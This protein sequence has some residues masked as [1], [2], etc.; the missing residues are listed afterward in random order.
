MATNTLTVT[1]QANF[2]PEFWA[3]EALEAVEFAQ[4]IAK[5]VNRHWE[6]YVKSGDT[7]H[8]P[9]LSNMTASTKSADT[10]VTFEQM[11]PSNAEGVQ[12]LTVGTHVYAAFKIEQITQVQGN[13]DQRG[14]YTKKIGYALNRKVETTISAL[15]DSLTNTV[16]SAG[17]ELVDENLLRAW[18]YL[19]DAGLL[20][21]SPDPGE[22]FSL[23]VSPAAYAG[24]MKIDR[25]ISRDYNAA[26]D[27][28][29]RAHVG[30]IYGFNVYVSNL[31]ES[32][33]TGQHDSVAMHR[34]CFALIQQQGVV[35][36]SDRIIEDIAD[37]VVGHT[38]FGVTE[39]NFPPEVEGGDATAVDDRGVYVKGV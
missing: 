28:V 30:Q 29:A 39:M 16:G 26:A 33:A 13:Q 31:L 22:E 3:T 4:V 27:A 1:T 9:R 24:L 36:E 38:L 20:E 10:L 32:D 18:Q 35:V 8:I 21:M 2:I 15:F 12:D 19:A 25:Y 7:L 37:A 5:R 23:I 14:K 11:G 17:V 6:Q 34:D